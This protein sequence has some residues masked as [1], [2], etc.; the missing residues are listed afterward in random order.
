MIR[1]RNLYVMFFLGLSTFVIGGIT[2]VIIFHRHIPDELIDYRDRVMAARSIKAHIE[3]HFPFMRPSLKEDMDVASL[4]TL[5]DEA[6]AR[7]RRSKLISYIWSGQTNDLPKTL[8]AKK[9]EFP[10]T[11]EGWMA[12]A[13]KASALRHEQEFGITTNSI[14]YSPEKPRPCAVIYHAGHKGDAFSWE[15]LF[16]Y[17]LKSRCHLITMFMPFESPFDGNKISTH[18]YGTIVVNHFTLSLLKTD[19]YTPMKLFAQPII[20]VVNELD[21][22]GIDEIDMVGFSGGGW[23]TTLAAALEPRIRQSISIAGS[24]P[25]F[26]LTNTKYSPQTILDFEQ[27]DGDLYNIANFIELYTLGAMGNGRSQ[28]HILLYRGGVFVGRYGFLYGDVIQDFL[29]S[30]QEC[31]GEFSIKLYT[32]ASEHDFSKQAEDMAIETLKEHIQR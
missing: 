31:G 27:T 17:V 14:L 28:T 32:D 8:P 11:D 25:A 6:S 18:K 30:C 19:T 5:S 13:H 2:G 24:M 15:K 29:E 10:L 9:K 26:I 12:H 22:M 4:L 16:S 1:R 21:R 7:A 3:N 20:E 23:S